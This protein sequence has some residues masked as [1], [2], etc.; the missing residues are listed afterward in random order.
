VR[1]SPSADKFESHR[2]WY[3]ATEVAAAEKANGDV[4]K[5]MARCFVIFPFQSVDYDSICRRVWYLVYMIVYFI[6][7]SLD[8]FATLV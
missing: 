1:L 4:H 2:V 6:D 8:E 3:L 7:D 5:Q